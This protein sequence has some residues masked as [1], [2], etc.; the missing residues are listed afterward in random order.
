MTTTSTSQCDRKNRQI[1]GLIVSK[2]IEI[3]QYAD[4]TILMLSTVS[5]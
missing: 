2:K 3:S 1:K 5:V 4:D